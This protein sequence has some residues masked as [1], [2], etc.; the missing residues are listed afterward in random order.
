MPL[1]EGRTRLEL[2]GLECRE[3]ALVHVRTA[4][5]LFESLG[6]RRDADAAAA[7]LRNLGVSGRSPKRIEGEL[8]R[9]TRSARPARRRSV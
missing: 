6:A 1:E 3:M 8:T 5:A 9:D 4:M 7:L 2:A